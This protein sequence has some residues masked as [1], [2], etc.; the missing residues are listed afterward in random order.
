MS[1][2]DVLFKNNSASLSAS[3]SLDGGQ[4]EEHEAVRKH[5][6]AA[7]A[8]SL[9]LTFTFVGEQV[10]AFSGGYRDCASPRLHLPSQ[11]PPSNRQHIP[12]LGAQVTEVRRRECGWK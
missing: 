7:W 3:G 5:F 12:G 6:P 2:R 11:S 10:R 1:P 4:E 9:T 8:A